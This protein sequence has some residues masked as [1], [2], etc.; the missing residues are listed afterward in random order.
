MPAPRQERRSLRDWTDA[1]GT[2]HLHL[3]H[4]PEVGAQ[5]MA[6]LAPRRDRLFHR[7]RTEGRR[8]PLEAYAADALVETVCPRA[9]GEGKREEPPP[10]RA[11]TKV[12]VRVDLPA[13]LRGRPVSG[14]TCEIAGFG[15]VAVSAVRDLLDTADPFLARW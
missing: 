6:A 15:P 2:W 13:L 9:E 12:I 4:N 7:A 14:E 3:R 11:G 5:F 10:A 8:E 1:E